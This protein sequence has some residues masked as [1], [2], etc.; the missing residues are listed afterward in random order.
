MTATVPKPLPRG[1]NA[2]IGPGVPTRLS[3][4][5]TGQPGPDSSPARVAVVG[6]GAW[7][8]REH[9]RAFSVR[10]DSELCAVVG[11]SSATAEARGRE[12]SVPWYTDVS[13]MLEAEQP[14][15]VSVTLPNEAHFDTTLA[16]IRAGVPLLVEKPLVF[17]LAEADQLLAEAAQRDLFFAI[18]FNHRYAHPVQL[19][20][21]AMIDGKLGDLVFATWRFGGEAGTSAHPHANLI[22]TQCHG[23][24]M[25]EYLAGPIESVAAQMTD[26]TG[27]GFST[28]T[29]ALR[30]ASGAVG[31]LVGSYDSSYAY[32]ATHHLELNGTAGR[33]VVTDTVG[34]F[35]LSRVGEETREVW[36]PGYFND[37]DRQFH[38]MFDRHLDDVLRALRAGDE[39][40]V[41]ARAGRRA[42]QLALAAVSSFETGRRVDTPLD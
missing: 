39:P 32:P 7:W 37:N 42:L 35:E 1:E 29:V 12:Y 18:N 14:D 38:R 22:E 21:Q 13:A 34:Q 41:H 5:Y 19:A 31:S 15:L 8:G 4:P 11:R 40:P 3:A 26:I 9:L 36:Q 30:F 24:D 10:S 17:D 23:F 33:A 25:L 20:H 6:T 27:K 2:L 16:L 28:M